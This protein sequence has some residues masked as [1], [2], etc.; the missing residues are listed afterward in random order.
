MIVRG[1]Q[2]PQLTQIKEFCR[3]L[4]GSLAARRHH[5]P[6]FPARLSAG[7]GA[8]KPFEHRHFSGLRNVI[9]L[10]RPRYQRGIFVETASS[11]RL[12]ITLS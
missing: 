2:C 9:F 5:V 3:T 8:A 7:A 11:N 1:G 12:G 10:A 6:R 4:E